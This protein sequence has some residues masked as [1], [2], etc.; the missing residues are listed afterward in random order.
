M[1]FDRNL[2]LNLNRNLNLNLNPNLNLCGRSAGEIKIRIKIKIKRQLG[3]LEGL[4]Q[5][6][7][8]LWT[9]ANNAA[10]WGVDVRYEHEGDR[11]DK[12]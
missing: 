8:I 2:N 11:D 7:Q 5:A 10:V 3:R 4:N 9:H 6:H 12:G 1:K